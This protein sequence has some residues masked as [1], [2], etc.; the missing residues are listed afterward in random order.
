M[1]RGPP[2]KESC[3]GRAKNLE[4]QEQG[5]LPPARQLLGTQARPFLPRVAVF[6]KH[7][8]S[9]CQR[10]R[11]LAPAGAPGV[12]MREVGVRGR[13]LGGASKSEWLPGIQRHGAGQVSTPAARY[14]VGLLTVCLCGEEGPL[15]APGSP[16]RGFRTKHASQAHRALTHVPQTL[17][18]WYRA[19]Q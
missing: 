6:Q 11:L 10:I 17:P 5:A 4:V 18:G 2:G 15:E 13:S 7:Q 3:A 16:I 14:G 1:A 12:A 8:P 19:P 9:Q